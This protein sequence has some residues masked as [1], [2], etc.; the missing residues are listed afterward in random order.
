MSQSQALSQWVEVVSSKMRH[1][2]DNQVR[3]LAMYSFGMVMTQSCGISS[4]ACFLAA[5][6]DR[7]ENSVR[8]QLRE[9]YFEA[10]AKRGDKRKEIVVRDSFAPLLSWVLSWWS[11]DE[12]R[13]ALV[14]DASNL[15]D[16][17]TVLAVSVVYR[18]CA[19]PVAWV[20]IPQ[21][22]KGSWRPHWQALLD[23]LHSS[24]PPDWTVIVL[25][26]RGLYAKWL[27]KMIQNCGWHPFLRINQQGLYRKKGEHR[28]YPLAT[29][30]GPHRTSWCGQVDCFKT[31]AAQL[32]CTLLAMWDENYTDPWLIL[33]DLLPT[34]AN[35]AWYG[36]RSW[37]EAGFKDTKRGGWRWEQT[38]MTDP[39]RVER[40]WLVIAVATL[41]VV[42][43]GATAED[44]LPASSF[45]ALPDTHVAK[46]RYSSKQSRPRL[47]SCF[48]RG[49]INILVTLIRGETLPIG[50]LLPSTWPD[51]FPERAPP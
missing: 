16:R 26:D 21:A 42:S 46:R 27:F 22:K 3:V 23:Q 17:F 34:Q 38:K 5:L 12:K 33:T 37:I 45:D 8:Q 39:A 19:I 1:L 32:S 41:W 15:R 11:P 18:G 2:S 43:V 50:R 4:I 40:L 7:K 29:L 28:F 10:S 51:T 44:A 47:L 6:L 14:L 35:V 9:W 31:Q 20:I 30:V 25:A 24:V 36:M 13:L 49:I 48:R